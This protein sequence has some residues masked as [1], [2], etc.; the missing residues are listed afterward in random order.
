VVSSSEQMA[1]DTTQ[2]LHGAGH[3]EK[4]S[5]M[6]SGL[7]A[8][9]LALALPCRLVGDLCSIVFVLLGTVSHGRHHG[10]VRRCVACL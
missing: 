9:Y 3:G 10:A 8:E 1:A 4:A 2:I 5:R 7:E 6:G